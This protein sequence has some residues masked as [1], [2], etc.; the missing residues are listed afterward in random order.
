MLK[1]CSLLIV[2][3]K[4][5]C[6]RKWSDLDVGLVKSG[7]KTLESLVAFVFFSEES[8]GFHLSEFVEF[9]SFIQCDS[10]SIQVPHHTCFSLGS[11][12][13]KSVKEQTKIQAR[14]AHRWSK[15]WLQSSISNYLV[16]GYV[17]NSVK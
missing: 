5:L 15:N 10:S 16:G 13:R 8:A 6:K 9:V 12:Y 17:R 11:I 3:L 2:V 7:Q 14:H 4:L 1:I